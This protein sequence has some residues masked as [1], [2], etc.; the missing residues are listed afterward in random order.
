MGLLGR[1][2]RFLGGERGRLYFFIR[3]ARKGLRSGGARG[4]GVFIWRGG[5]CR[6][7]LICRREPFYCYNIIDTLAAN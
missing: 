3:G 2:R 4:L 5:C 6:L 1:L 7:A